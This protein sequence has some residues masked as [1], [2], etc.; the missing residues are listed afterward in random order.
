MSTPVT[1]PHP[2]W[3]LAID[4]GP[5]LVF[6]ITYKLSGGEGPIAQIRAIMVST[7]VFMVATVIALAVSRIR[8]GRISPMLWLSTILIVGFGGLTIWLHDARFIQTKPTA[9]YLLLGGILLGGLAFGR[10]LL[11]IVL[12][13]GY[14]GLT[15]RGWYLMSRNWGLFFIAM[16]A[17]NEVLRANLNFAD[18]LSV[19]LWLL[20]LLSIGF[21][22]SQ[23]PLAIRH[24][25]GSDDQA[26]AVVPPVD[27]SI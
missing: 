13:A 14:D 10:S 17:I 3:T 11:K 8:L 18:W 4:Y 23:I 22:L 2:G 24:G 27:G 25:L 6:F 20:P 16:A 9:I 19:K 7:G 5:L 15:D 1:K 21:T 26:S 12:E